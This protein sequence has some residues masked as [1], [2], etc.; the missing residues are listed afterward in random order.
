MSRFSDYKSYFE[1]HIYDR[2]IDISQTNTVTITSISE[3][4]VHA[5]VEGSEFY[6]VYLG[7]VNQHLTVSCSC[8]YAETERLCKHMAAVMIVAEKL[9]DPESN[10]KNIQI[11]HKSALIVIMRNKAGC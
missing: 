6:N 3:N 11:L 2:G 7:V 8:P 4:E 9:T 10:K 5:T 1:P